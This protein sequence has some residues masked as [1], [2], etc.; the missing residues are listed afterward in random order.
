MNYGIR[1]EKL[2][3]ELRTIEWSEPLHV[4]GELR[5]KVG[6]LRVGC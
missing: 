6:I 3:K 4:V 1:A 5:A 2:G